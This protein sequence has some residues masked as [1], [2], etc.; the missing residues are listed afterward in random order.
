MLVLVLTLLGD[1]T[2]RYDTMSIFRNPLES[3]KGLFSKN[4]RHSYTR[5]SSSST[6]KEKPKQEETF[7]FWEMLKSDP[8]KPKEGKKDAQVCFDYH[9]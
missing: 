5:L 3:L 8:E 6:D 9:I 1:I 4:H 7:T 2:L